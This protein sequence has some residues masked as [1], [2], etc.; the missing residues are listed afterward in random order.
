MATDAIGRLMYSYK[1]LAELA[2]YTSR[3]SLLLD[4]ISDVRRSK[5][6]KTLVNTGTMGE[7]IASK[8]DIWPIHKSTSDLIPVVLHGRGQIFSSDDIEFENVPIIT[9]NGDVLLRSL[10]FM[11][12]PGVRL[13]FSCLKAYQS[14]LSRNTCLLLVQMVVID[15]FTMSSNADIVQ[16]LESRHYSAFLG[17][18][19]PSTVRSLTKH[20]QQLT[21]CF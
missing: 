7:N 3:V 1:D 21:Y 11:V 19:G 12:K 17:V 5:F 8:Q 6:E 16:G 10:T 13:G 2:G 9:P 14:L 20:I 15:P 4:T 18:S